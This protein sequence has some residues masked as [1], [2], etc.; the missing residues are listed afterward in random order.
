MAKLFAAEIWENTEL[1]FKHS[2]ASLTLPTEDKG[3]VTVLTGY[4]PSVLYLEPGVV[5]AKSYDGM[6]RYFAIRGGEAEVTRNGVKVVSP[7]VLTPGH[8]DVEDA[9]TEYSYATS[10][11]ASPD[12]PARKLAGVKSIQ[13]WARA[14]L[15]VARKETSGM[16]DLAR[17]SEDSEADP[18]RL[19]DHL[20][21]DRV[22][23]DMKAT[24]RWQAIEELVD[25]LSQ[26]LELSKRARKNVLE[27]VTSREKMMS[28]AIGGRVAIPHCANCKVDRVAMALGISRQGIDFQ[29]LDNEPVNVVILTAIRKSKFNM[30]VRTLGGI[31][32]LFNRT[33]VFE[34]VMS[35]EAPD[36]L[37]QTIRRAENEVLIG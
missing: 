36:E 5:R 10:I 15:D 2:I 35:C 37:L 18:L 13:Q 12:T 14:R 32:R 22:L 27:Q 23:M 1:V 29:A 26:S 16:E 24:D 21:T 11:L 9:E 7:E 31:A 3:S 6:S 19:S 20:A 25:Q 30:Y 28:T 4:A 34:D 8:I 17:F 33:D